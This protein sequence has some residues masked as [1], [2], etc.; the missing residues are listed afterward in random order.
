MAL[1]FEDLT[2]VGHCFLFYF[3][4]LS[5]VVEDHGFLKFVVNPC[6][7][8]RNSRREALHVSVRLIIASFELWR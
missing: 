5:F 4:F 8:S 2:W 1:R 7:D 6:A 3:I